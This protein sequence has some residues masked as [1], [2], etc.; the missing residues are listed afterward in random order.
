MKR[1]AAEILKDALELP[2]EARAALAAWLLDSLDSHA[3]EDA[4]AAW[5]T[6]INRRVADLRSGTVL[7]IPWPRP[8]R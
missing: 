5:A 4:R 1:K 3:D 8:L 6:E 7:T 2:T